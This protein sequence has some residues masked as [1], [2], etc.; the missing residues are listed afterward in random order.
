VAQPDSALIRTDTLNLSFA[1]APTNS[2]LLRDN[3]H[4]RHVSAGTDTALVRTDIGTAT[5]SLS[6]IPAEERTVLVRKHNDHV[7]FAKVQYDM[8]EQKIGT[9]AE[10]TVVMW[11][12]TNASRTISHY[13]ETA[14]GATDCGLG[15]IDREYDGWAVCTGRTYTVTYLVGP[16]AGTTETFRTPDLR[17]KFIVGAE[18]NGPGFGAQ[19]NISVGALTTY[20]IEAQGGWEK[21]HLSI[22][23]LPKHV[24]NVSSVDPGHDHSY[25]Q[26][27]KKR[28]DATWKNEDGANPPKDG[29]TG[30]RKTGIKDTAPTGGDLSH[31]NRPPYYA[32]Y[33]IIKLV[34]GRRNKD[35][36]LGSSTGSP[37]PPTVLPT[38]TPVPTPVPPPVGHQVFWTNAVGYDITNTF[39][40]WGITSP[41]SVYA[42]G[43]LQEVSSTVYIKN[44][45]LS[46]PVTLDITGI[47]SGGD[48]ELKN[49]PSLTRVI[50][51]SNVDSLDITG[52]S[53]IQQLDISQNKLTSLNVNPCS[54][55]L[56]VLNCEDN[57]LLTTVT[58]LNA[59]SN[60]EELNCA[61][62]INMT[63]ATFPTANTIKR[64]D[65]TDTK[66]TNISLANKTNLEYLAASNILNLT[67]DIKGCS[68]LETLD[69]GGSTFTNLQHNSGTFTKLKVIVL[70]GSTMS[71]SEIIDILNG[72]TV[73]NGSINFGSGYPAGLSSA[74]GYNPARTNAVT[75]KAWAI[76]PALPP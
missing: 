54:S 18:F 6:F 41:T 53:N 49:M 12:P 56:K 30:K 60:L 9:I 29:V 45:V 35:W 42:A 48:V 32:L 10:G 25:K 14:A 71:P 19:T 38:A 57:N 67:I 33:Y 5:Q 51:N 36:S 16:N 72:L 2:A 52:S 13:F 68:T 22:P 64:V 61:G 43:N 23:E 75:T 70:Q 50:L 46:T 47:A 26:N 31:E 62:C 55:S 3:D 76:T 37:P 4:L 11:Y 7:E 44:T 73:T 39:G 66:V 34:S 63:T 58:N 74:V 65:L 59:C 27:S 24:H 1:V 21:H 28:I 20:N 40:A 8:F 15:R 69:L 17:S